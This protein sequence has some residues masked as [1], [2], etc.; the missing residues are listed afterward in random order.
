M[1]EGSELEFSLELVSE[2][3]LEVAVEIPDLEPVVVAV[4]GEIELG[5]VFAI[6]AAGVPCVLVVGIQADLVIF[7]VQ[8][9]VVV[10]RAV[11]SCTTG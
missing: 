8:M 3:E 2:V 7:V 4:A 11:N 6:V 5:V 10:G 9:L 1:S